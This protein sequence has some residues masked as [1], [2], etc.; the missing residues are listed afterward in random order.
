M[1]LK[2]EIHGVH[3][4]VHR[5]DSEMLELYTEKH[6]RVTVWGCVSSEMLGEM[7]GRVTAEDLE[8]NEYELVIHFPGG[9]R[10]RTEDV[11]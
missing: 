2:K 4:R 3:V 5:D 6:G 11:I 9:R 7:M 8:N 1:Q 10:V